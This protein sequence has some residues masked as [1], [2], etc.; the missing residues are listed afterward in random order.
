MF[1]FHV[2][3]L[4]WTLW[5][6]NFPLTV[7]AASSQAGEFACLAAREFTSFERI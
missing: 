2:F 3:R 5:R 6:Q 7:G 4:S 1:G